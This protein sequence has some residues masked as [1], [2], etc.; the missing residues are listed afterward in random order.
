MTKNDNKE[1][2]DKNDKIDKKFFQKKNCGKKNF[3]KKSIKNSMT[4]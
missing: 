2:N 4:N 3:T 1:K